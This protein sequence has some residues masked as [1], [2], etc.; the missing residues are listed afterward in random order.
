M[1][2]KGQQADMAGNLT[3]KSNV[4]GMIGTNSYLLINNTTKEAIIVDPGAE[5]GRIEKSVKDNEVTPAAI[6]LTHG[7]FD[8]I[9]AANELREL[10]GIP[11]CAG[12][13]EEQLLASSMLNLS[14]DY[15]CTCTVKPDRLF[16][17]GE[18]VMLAGFDIEVIATPGH[19]GGCVCYYFEQESVLISGDTLFHNAVGRTDLATGS[20]KAIIQSVH[21][22]I[23]QLP[24]DTK[25]YPGH[26][27]PTDIGWE[28]ENNPYCYDIS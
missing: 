9:L 13:E 15:G 23:K 22:L 16:E 10:Y 25:V 6:L 21:R 26:G 4:V 18:H 27:A 20:S 11:V 7:H 24:A 12:R 14:T 8:H 5:A 1:I 17:D 19:T 3:V 28:E 2:L